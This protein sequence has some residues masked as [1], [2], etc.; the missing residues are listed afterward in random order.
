MNFLKRIFQKQDPSTL[1]CVTY[2]DTNTFRRDRVMAILK[3]AGVEVKPSADHL[4]V[5]QDHYDHAMSI[6]KGHGY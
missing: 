2:I 6:L 5:K 3:E 1:W 4:L